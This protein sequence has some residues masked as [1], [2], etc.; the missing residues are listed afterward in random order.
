MG[1]IRPMG[2]RVWSVP[3]NAPQKSGPYLHLG[4]IVH[5]N[6]YGKHMIYLNTLEAA[7]DLLEK[8]WSIYSDRF[9]YTM[10]LDL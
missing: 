4:K 8:R 5:V 1:D 2:K 9:E 3:D 6:V 10:L 7:K